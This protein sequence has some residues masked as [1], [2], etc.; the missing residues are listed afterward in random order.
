MGTHEQ[1]GVVGCA[2]VTEYENDVIKKH[3]KTRPDK[4][5][6]RTRHI[7]VLR[8]HD[9][10][11]FL[12]Y[13]ASSV[14]DEL[15]ARARAA[16]PT[17]DFATPDGVEHRLWV[18]GAGETRKLEDAFRSVPTLYVADGHHRSAAAARAHRRLAGDGGEHDVFSRR[19]LPP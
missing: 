4:E 17:Y 3:E 19:H 8:A 7:E 9:E 5:D 6:D 14:I 11:V 15:V 2:S 1:I 10:P 12:T 18:L 13:R 16:S